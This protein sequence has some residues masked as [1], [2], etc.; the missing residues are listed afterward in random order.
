MTTPLM[1]RFAIWQ[2]SI[3]RM[4]NASERFDAELTRRLAA[5][6][7]QVNRERIFPCAIQKAQFGTK[8]SGHL[9]ELRSFVSIEI[10]TLVDHES[11][12]TVPYGSI[13]RALQFPKALSERIR[14]LLG[15]DQSIDVVCQISHRYVRPH[16]PPPAD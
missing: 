8:A 2:R 9:S 13:D 16:T 14:D 10:E 3:D 5:A 11:G 4:W 6:V 7:A 15:I 1:R 12:E